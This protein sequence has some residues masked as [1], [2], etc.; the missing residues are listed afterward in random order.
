MPLP[1]WY[2]ILRMSPA[3]IGGLV[4]VGFG[5]YLVVAPISYRNPNDPKLVVDAN[6]LHPVVIVIGV[7]MLLIGLWA[8]Y[9]GVTRF[10][11][12]P[13]R[14]REFSYEQLRLGQ[15]LAA[16]IVR[17]SSGDEYHS[18]SAE[19]PDGSR[20]HVSAHSYYS[21]KR[22]LRHRLIEWLNTGF[23]DT[24]HFSRAQPGTEVDEVLHV[25]EV[26]FF[27]DTFTGKASRHESIV[28]YEIVE[29]PPIVEEG[30]LLEYAI[31][32]MIAEGDADEE[33]LRELVEPSFR[34]VHAPRE[35]TDDPSAYYRFMRQ[36]GLDKPSAEEL[37][38]ALDE[39][40]EW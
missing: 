4:L 37:R 6:R 11:R 21:R 10:N 29:T 2:R 3:V 26:G 16:E 5:I 12:M 15:S 1:T 32:E 38:I 34:L 13:E 39:L 7:A 9:F 20:L 23:G 18:W 17:L 24:V 22:S 40:K 25:P 31:R 33:E 36:M 30:S 19:Y 8:L 14:L 35:E 27:I 28:K